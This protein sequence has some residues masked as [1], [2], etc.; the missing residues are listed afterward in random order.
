M[1]SS[2]GLSPLYA[3]VAIAI[4][5]GDWSGSG[6]ARAMK[7]HISGVAFKNLLNRMQQAGLVGTRRGG[8]TL[9]LSGMQLLPRTVEAPPM[10][11]YRPPA[12]MLRRPGSDDAHRLP[13]MAAGQ[14]RDY[15]PHV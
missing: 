14:L 2:D 8:W 7:A 4:A 9:T 5:R 6:V 11:P 15:F 10:V 3:K 13:S 12:P 1:S